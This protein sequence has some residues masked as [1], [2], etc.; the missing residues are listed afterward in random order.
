M[1]QVK[2][3]KETKY[4]PSIKKW[5][6]SMTLPEYGYW[7]ESAFNED[8][9]KAEE[10]VLEA[11]KKHVAFIREMRASSEKEEIVLSI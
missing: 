11:V 2:I 7:G 5:C 10:E 3:T 1:E 4:W 6:V 9:K 8:A